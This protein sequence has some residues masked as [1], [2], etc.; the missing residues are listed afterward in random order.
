MSFAVIVSGIFSLAKSVP[1]IA[2]YIDMFIDFYV[3]KQIEKLDK[4]R[5]DKKDK[6]ATLMRAISKADND[7]ERKA[8]SIILNDIMRM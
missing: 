4:Y 1:I 5:I 8:L 7:V 6:R 2:S 3:D